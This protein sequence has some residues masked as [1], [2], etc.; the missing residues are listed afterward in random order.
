MSRGIQ[1]LA[2]ELAQLHMGWL[3][4]I[5]MNVMVY[6]CHPR[7]LSLTRAV[8]GCGFIHVFLII[9]LNSFDDIVTQ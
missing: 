2:L 1:L 6:T 8:S 7:V 3:R 4:L 5:T 9:P